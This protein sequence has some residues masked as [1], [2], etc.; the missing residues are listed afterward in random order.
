M[1]D[2]LIELVCFTFLNEALWV[3]FIR[4]FNW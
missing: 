1:D 4:D 3:D 2:K